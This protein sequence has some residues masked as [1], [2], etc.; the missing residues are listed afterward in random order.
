VTFTWLV[1]SRAV[2]FAACLLVVATL[3]LDRLIVAPTG[4]TAGVR[5]Q[6]IA[7]WLL[8]TAL[9]AALLSGFSWFGALAADMSGLPPTQALHPTILQLVWTKTHFGRLWQLRLILWACAAVL[10]SARRIGPLK[11]AATWLALAC[12]AALSSSLAWAGHGLVGNPQGWHLLTDATHLLIAG[13]WPAGLLPFG[14]LL[15]RLLREPTPRNLES[16]SA[17]TY[18]FSAMSLAS[19]ALLAASGL[20]NSWFLVGSIPRLWQT[21]Y[22]R[23]LLAKVAVFVVMIGIGAINLLRLKPRASNQM[24]AARLRWNV[25]AEAMLA[26]AVIVLV[27]IL[28]LLQP[29]C[30]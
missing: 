13:F 27:A 29:A 26:G 19:V 25:G 9:A 14:L 18:R 3:A 7:R 4:G 2:H 28:G 22:G 30:H 1:L 5:W 8:L 12:A 10:V 21:A 11:T 20:G 6:R 24:V 16:I 17:L 23:V 15:A